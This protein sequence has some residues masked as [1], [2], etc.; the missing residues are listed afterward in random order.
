MKERV[1]NAGCERRKEKEREGEKER[2]R[3]REG[4]KADVMYTNS[5][6]Y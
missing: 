4:E 1:R 6:T 3:D 2:R 5:C